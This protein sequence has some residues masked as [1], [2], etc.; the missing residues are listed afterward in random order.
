MIREANYSTMVTTQGPSKINAITQFLLT[1]N[2]FS[3]HYTKKS[4]FITSEFKQ[5]WL[6]FQNKKGKGKDFQSYQY[7][8]AK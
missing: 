2:E 7:C 4:F 3:F 5:F 8:E 1:P 6:H